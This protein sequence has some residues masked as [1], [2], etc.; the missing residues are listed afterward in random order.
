MRRSVP[1]RRG[2][3]TPPKPIIGRRGFAFLLCIALA[4]GLFV[5]VTP[6]R[7]S[8]DALSDAY[9]KQKAL[10]R[11]IARQR[12]AIAALAANQTALSGRIASTKG[13]L[14]S[15]ISNIAAVQTDIVSMT[16]H[17]VH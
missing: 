15:V 2:W 17:V 3:S 16:G 14:A 8:A 11:Q 1:D 13:T 7:A 4:G 6:P 10:Q 9:A 5:S 12:A